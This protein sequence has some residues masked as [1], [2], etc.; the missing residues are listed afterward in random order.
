[1]TKRLPLCPVCHVPVNGVAY[2]A[3]A[4]RL[5][6]NPLADAWEEHPPQEI[7]VTLAC[8]GQVWRETMPSGLQ[9]R[10]VRG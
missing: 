7:A 9:P 8:H 2:V 6:W 1:M 10:I 4:P 5:A 3:A